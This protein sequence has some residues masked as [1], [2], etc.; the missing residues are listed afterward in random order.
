MDKQ[1]LTLREKQQVFLD[2]LKDLDGF[3]TEHGIVYYIGCGT[4]LGAVRHKG[5][6][7]WDN[8]IDVFMPCPDFKR[9]S[10]EYYSSKY[11]LH[12]CYNDLAHPFSFGLLCDS[13][14]YTDYFKHK[15]YTCGID[16]YVIHGAPTDPDEQIK[17][18]DSVKRII[19]RKNFILKL[20]NNLAKRGLWPFKTLNSKR[21]NHLLRKANAEFEKYSFEKCEYIW[22]YGG[23][24]LILKKELYG[25]P[26]RL[27]F[28]DGLFL[29]PQHYHEVLTAGY[30]DYMVLPPVNQ[31]NKGEGRIPY[32][33]DI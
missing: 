29:A 33:W 8:D 16:I 13:R 31:R 25:D 21:M 11:T 32:Y 28:E 4:L 15:Q 10:H 14:I 18:M 1:P 12:T 5:Y 26:I 24:R 2:I 6:I 9:F 17:H 22:P 30:G 7:P 20:R 27:P 19:K 3:C 23:G